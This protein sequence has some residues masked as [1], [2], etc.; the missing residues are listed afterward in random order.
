LIKWLGTR[1]PETI[2]N[3]QF[4]FRIPE[5]E[6]EE[7]EEE[8]HHPERS[9]IFFTLKSQKTGVRSYGYFASYIQ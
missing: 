1:Q 7:E 6:Y 4:F 8:I 9:L 5:E 2:L 3:G